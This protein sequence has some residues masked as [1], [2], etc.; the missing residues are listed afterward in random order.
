MVTATPRLAFAQRRRLFVEGLV[1][2]VA[3]SVAFAL[4]FA[5][6]A[7]AGLFP[8]EFAVHGV[9][10]LFTLAILNVLYWYAGAWAGFPTRH[11]AAHWGID[12]ALLTLLIHFIGGMDTPYAALAYSGLVTF[13]AV[14]E[15]RVVALRLAMLSLVSFG[16]LVALEAS[17]RLPAPGIWIHRY[18]A[19]A[20]IVSV[21]AP[22]IF[23]Y[24]IAWVGGTL[25]DNLK[26]ANDSL[27]EFGA[28]IEEQNRSLERRVEERT[29]E[30]ARANAEIEDLVHI[31]THDLKNVSVAATE[32]A[33][34]LI[35]VESGALSPRGRRY[36]D[37]LLED[38]RTM[39]RMLENLLSL[40]RAAEPE[41]ERR[42]Q[43]DVGRIVR[44]V[45]DRLQ[46]RI[47]AR[48]IEVRIGPLPSAFA[49]AAKIRH[50]FDNLVDNA[51]KYVG[52]A[53]P[54]V[55]EIAGERR[56][57]EVVYWVRDNGIGIDEHQLARIFQLYHRS[58]E[59][60]VAGEEQQG[61]GVGLAIVK[62]I[63]ER[64]GGRIRVDSRPGEGATFTVSLPVAEGL[65]A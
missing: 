41:A 28:R 52:D 25:A 35:D 4:M 37:H 23:I 7:A 40:F 36:A 21:V 17:G 55:V 12:I 64:H 63:V 54:A 44:E 13:A 46:H 15:S 56:G 58:P 11:F 20:R 57:A 8:G 31:V 6:L 22:F 33:R 34:K 39:S 19:N 29:A 43:V 27:T 61:H 62:R 16:L 3:L 51:C 9:M 10:V 42:E 30:L 53:V 50:V 60:R 47:E 24:G 18:S 14:N 2:R 45:V 49:E 38:T 59:Q 65:A 1:F 26:A 32:M 5:V 48:S